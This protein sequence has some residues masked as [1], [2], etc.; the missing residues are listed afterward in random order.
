MHLFVVWADSGINV[1]V[2]V[3]CFFSGILIFKVVRNPMVEKPN[4]DGKPPA[5]EYQED[6][7]LVCIFMLNLLYCNESL[8]LPTLNCH[9]FI[10]HIISRLLRMMTVSCYTV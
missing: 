6:E 8:L 9:A 1:S 7:I 10:L 4:K 2:L 3:S 5:I